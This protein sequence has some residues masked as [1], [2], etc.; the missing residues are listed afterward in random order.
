[1]D[2]RRGVWNGPLEV[3]LVMREEL[4]RV[5]YDDHHGSSIVDISLLIVL[6]SPVI[7]NLLAALQVY[8]LY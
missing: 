1:M 7:K 5:S 8:P 3:L 2:A 6:I 4:L